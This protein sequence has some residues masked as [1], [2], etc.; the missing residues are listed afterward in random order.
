MANLWD[1]S[2]EEVNLVNIGANKGYNLVEWLENFRL[3]PPNVSVSSWGHRLIG[4]FPRE[5]RWRICGTCGECKPEPQNLEEG[6]IYRGPGKGVHI[7]ALEPSI[8]NFKL[9][10]DLK[11]WA[12]YG[13]ITL[14]QAAA[15]NQSG[16]LQFPVTEVGF[17]MGS[18]TETHTAKTVDVRVFTVEEFMEEHKI[19]R[20]NYLQVDTEGH[21]PLVISSAHKALKEHRID[22]LEFEYHFFAHWKKTKLR[23]VVEDFDSL[24]YDCFLELWR[25]PSTA[26]HLVCLTGCWENSYDFHDWS[27]VLC[28]SRKNIALTN[29]LRSMCKWL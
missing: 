1:P 29:F 13:K 28:S 9:L 21:D 19:E 26:D 25:A 18:L 3:A 8:T 23:N 24:G 22:L 11:S 7:Y 17:T 10:L 6:V 5:A 14:L 20:I 2:K 27:N 4:Q 16:V 15:S 12:G